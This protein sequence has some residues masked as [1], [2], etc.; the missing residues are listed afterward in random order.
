VCINQTRDKIIDILLL[1]Y[2]YLTLYFYHAHQ[3]NF[4]ETNFDG[5]EGGSPTSGKIEG[6]NVYK[7]CC[8]GENRDIK[9][10]PR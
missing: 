2:Q 7:Q 4:K 6:L 5:L 9:R 1:S 3:T 10:G 8:K